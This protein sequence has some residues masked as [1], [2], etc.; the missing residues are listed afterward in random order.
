MTVSKDKVVSIEYTLTG[1]DGSVIDTSEGRGALSYIHGHGNLVSGLEKE[2]EGKE[3]GAAFNTSIS[4]QEGYGDYD[5]GLLFSVPKE[6][7]NEFGDLEIGMQFQAETD[8]GHQIMEIKSIE[9]ESV[10]V[11]ANHPLAGQN[12]HFEGTIV[13]VREATGDELSHGHVHEEGHDHQG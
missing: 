11:D 8:R 3:D 5:D 13:G 12:L 4:P 9:D 10:L 7:F 6:R 2:L 1:D